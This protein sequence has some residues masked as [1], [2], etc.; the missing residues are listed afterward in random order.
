MA[1]HATLETLDGATIPLA[2]LWA[3]GPVLLLFLRHF[4]CPSC[5]VRI[6]RWLRFISCR[7]MKIS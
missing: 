4:A 7:W 6:D 3:D 5:S 2:S 1:P